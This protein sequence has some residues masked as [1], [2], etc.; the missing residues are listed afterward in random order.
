[1]T[2]NSYASLNISAEARAALVTSAAML[3]SFGSALLLERLAGLNVDVIVLAVVLSLTLGRIRSGGLLR[4]QAVSFAVLVGVTLAAGQVGVL[5]RDHPN[6]GDALFT[7]ALTLGVWIRRF[8]LRAG[9]AG[10]MVAL[11]FIGILVTPLPVPPG[12][13]ASLWGAAAAVIAFCWV[14]ILHEGAERTG[15][16]APTGQALPRAAP[17]RTTRFPASTRMAAQLGV[18]LAAAFTAGRLLYPAHW[19]W[20]VLT[21]YIV[22]SGN[23]GRGDVVLKSA[24]RVLGAAAGT[25]AATLLA[26]TFAPGSPASVAV[27]LGILAIAAP[28]RSYGYA[29]WAGS[30][31]AVL[32]LLYGYF[33]QSGADLLP[34]R[35]GAIAVGAVL[36]V[37]ASWLVLPVRSSQVLR[38]RAAD[39]LT[40]LTDLLA[41]PA[42]ETARHRFHHCVAQVDEVALP[43]Q[44]H[45]RLT[46][47]ATAHPADAVDVLR[48]C[49]PAADRAAADPSAAATLTR[50]RA[51]LARILVATR[52]PK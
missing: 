14:T 43:L 28:L 22:C 32:A 10:T 7:L 23:R 34:S 9:R 24:H 33:G 46:R 15:L 5:L 37:A 3:A 8:G 19:T 47:P 48:A 45:R 27:M 38:R 44:L 13:R 40:A 31:T 42:E 18:A 16:L 52:P 30:V 49:A 50:A 2:T 1:M 29:Y 11:P 26:G 6:L 4:D 35:L 36:A 17:R 12:P 39:A 51:D 41:A 21:A 25:I 20:V